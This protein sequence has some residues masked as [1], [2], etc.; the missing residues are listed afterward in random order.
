MLI[1]LIYL[2]ILTFF[3][4]FDICFYNQLLQMRRKCVNFWCGCMPQPAVEE[5]AALRLREVA[6]D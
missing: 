4:Y 5:W 2:S 1:S 3:F 6:D